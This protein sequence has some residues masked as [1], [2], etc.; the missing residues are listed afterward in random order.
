MDLHV[1]INNDTTLCP[2]WCSYEIAEALEIGD[3][4]IVFVFSHTDQIFS[5]FQFYHSHETLQQNEIF[6]IKSEFYILNVTMCV[7]VYTTLFWIVY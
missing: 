3:L 1:D 6:N 5:F 2:D 4:E 7:I